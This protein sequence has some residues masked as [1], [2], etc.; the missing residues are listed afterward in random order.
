M[1]KIALTD[2][3]TI[4]AAPERVFAILDDPQLRGHLLGGANAGGA[5]ACGGDSQAGA[6]FQH[7]VRRRG[8]EVTYDGEV[9]VREPPDR[10][11]M[12]I[13]D[14]RASLHADYHLTRVELNE[15]PA[16]L[17][18]CT[19]EI[20]SERKRHYLLLRLFRRLLQC[21]VRWQTRRLKQLAE[22][23]SRAPNADAAAATRLH[24]WQ[25][26][27][28]HYRGLMCWCAPGVHEAALQMLLTHVQRRGAAID[29][30]AGTGAWLA[31][32]MDAGF[33]NP[34]A[35]ELNAEWFELIGVEPCRLDLNT[36]FADQLGGRFDVVTAIEIL[37]HLDSPRRFLYQARKLLNDGGHLL[38]STPNIAHW[39][40]RLTFLR[41][42]EHRYFGEDEY[43]TQRHISPMTDLHM[44]LMFR[45]VGLQVVQ[46][47]TVGSYFGPLRKLV[48]LP[49]SL[50]FR[51]FCGPHTQGDVSIYLT[52]K[53]EP[54]RSSPGRDSHYLRSALFS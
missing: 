34:R 18:R 45:E 31:R 43:H 49:L 16:S 24:L 22:S 37:E 9:T 7:R 20:H 36:D 21:F 4:A 48:S 35:V 54:D 25:V 52:V 42:G 46:H 26:P 30:A 33:V 8:R 6:A 10:F 39:R 12:R 19:I 27:R 3:L 40:G 14:R 17:V 23:Y 44:R 2:C 15:Q 5:N 29:L 51:L 1:D 47:R 11:A 50:P 32:L 41:S 13:N 38:L 53:C 28:L